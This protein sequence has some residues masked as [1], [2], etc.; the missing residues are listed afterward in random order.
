MK[1]PVKVE[2]GPKAQHDPV[3]KDL[4]LK[5]DNVSKDWKS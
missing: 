5:V 3:Q 1:L 4:P 2:D